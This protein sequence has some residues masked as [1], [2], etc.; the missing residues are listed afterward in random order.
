MWRRNNIYRR[1]QGAANELHH[2]IKFLKIDYADEVRYLAL[3]GVID[4]SIVD[5]EPRFIALMSTN[6]G[7]SGNIEIGGAVIA[8][9][10]VKVL[11]CYA[12]VGAQYIGWENV[13]ET[14]ISCGEGSAT[15][16][17]DREVLENCFYLLRD[18]YPNCWTSYEDALRAIGGG[19]DGEVYVALFN[20]DWE[21]TR[22]E[23]FSVRGKKYYA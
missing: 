20:G 19:R 12:W 23:T 16:L 1:G 2:H 13:L 10:G 4:Q 14:G 5:E 21:P 7:L 22:Q 6:F 8:Y 17:D 11:T 3:D 18:I 9:E 15:H